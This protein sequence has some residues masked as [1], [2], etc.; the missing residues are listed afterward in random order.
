[1]PYPRARLD[2]IETALMAETDD[3]ILWPFAVRKSSGY[4]AYSEGHGATKK[5]YDV[6]RYVCTRAHGEP[7]LG[8]ETA[9]SCGQ[10]L[11]INQRHLTWKLPIDNMQDAKDHGTLRGGGRYRQRLF[12]SDR[13]QIQ[14]SKESLVTL[15]SRYGMEPSYIG[16]VRRSP[17]QFDL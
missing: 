9:H 12:A 10:K 16:K 15:A 1:M 5:N 13:A 2:F 8:E 6:H 17:P 11:C 7:E 4:G 14:A 3:C